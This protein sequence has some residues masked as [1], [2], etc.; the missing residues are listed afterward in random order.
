[1]KGGNH[2]RL[3]NKNRSVLSPED[4]AAAAAILDEVYVKEKGWISAAA[5]PAP[6]TGEDVTWFLCRSAGVPA[7]VLR[8]LY[9]P[10]LE[11]PSELGVTL[12]EGVDLKQ[13][14]A[15]HRFVEIG[16][17]AVVPRFR[18]NILISLRLMRAAIQEVVGRE[19]THFITDVFE[20]EV[21]SPYHFHTRILGF[22]VI[23]RHL[24]GDLQCSCTRII[25]TLDI[26]KAYRRLK[27]KRSRILSTLTDGI[28]ETLEKK[29]ASMFE[30]EDGEKSGKPT[31]AA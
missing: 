10:A 14:A 4:A 19:Y 8:L 16:R 23:G 27:Q 24:R 12:N 9:D 28:A 29:A 3:R 6:V 20:G 15:A 13:L 11:I 17:F 25:L 18:R 30:G 7:G 5:V 26:L 22:E 1:V 21:N 2:V 31:Y